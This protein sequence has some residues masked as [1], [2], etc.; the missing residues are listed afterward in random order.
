MLVYES[1]VVGENANNI[2]FSSSC[3]VDLV[4]L[5]Y[6]IWNTS[7]KSNFGCVNL[8]RKSY[9]ILNK[10]YSKE[11][12][13]KLR[14]QIIADT[15]KNLYIDKLGRKFSYGE[16][17]PLEIGKFPY[18]KSNAMRFFPKTKEEAL[19]QG[20]GWSDEENPTNVCTVK[21]VSLPET[22]QKTSDSILQE[23]IECGNCA[24]AYRITLGEFNLLRKMNLPVP[25]ECPKCRENNRFGRMTKPDMYHR[26]CDKCGDPIY[27]PYPP[28]DKR[29]V[30]C[31]KCYQQEFN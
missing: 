9:C 10:Q 6:C 12:F 15:K 27:T 5:E 26:N 25:H 28:E 2:K 16:F 13:N 7:G 18:N 1:S 31:V 8:K 19:G 20:Y 23:I 29:I 17:F 3:T 14:T 24:R 4:N 22:I 11:S 21:A 30:Y